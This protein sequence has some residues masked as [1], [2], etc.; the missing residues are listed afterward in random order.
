MLRRARIAA[1]SALD[2]ICRGTGLV[3]LR[4]PEE[5]LTNGIAWREHQAVYDV[6]A[7]VRPQEI[8]KVIH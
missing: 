6:V 1:L 5:G 8:N 3:P 2:R 4:R 7:G